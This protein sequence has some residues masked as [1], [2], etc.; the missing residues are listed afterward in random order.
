MSYKRYLLSSALF[1]A[2]TLMVSAGLSPNGAVVAKEAVTKPRI[3]L[4]FCI[5]TTGSMQNE[6]NAVKTKTKEIVAK[7]SG[8]KPAPDIRVGL[9]AYRD[10]GDAYLTKVFQFSDNIDQVV[11]DISSL[12]ANGGG[13]A[14]E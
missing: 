9:V 14:P 6:I 5:D 12:E 10:H 11:K 2:G 8:S 3:D 7:L 13:D 4:A 1:V